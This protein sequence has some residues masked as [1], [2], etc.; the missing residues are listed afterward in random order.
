MVNGLSHLR[1]FWQDFYPFLIAYFLFLIATFYSFRLLRKMTA[2]TLKNLLFNFFIFLFLLVNLFYALEIYYRYIFDATDNIFQIKTTQRW[3]DRHVVI[4]AFGF[5]NDHFF[6]DKAANEIRIMVLGDSYTWGYGIKNQADR[7]SDLLGQQLNQDCRNFG[8]TVKIYN[9]ALPGMSS[10]DE[11]KLI[12][13]YLLKYKI[14]AVVIAYYL[15]DGGSELTARHIQPCYNR[16]F[17]YRY[18]PVLREALNAS[19]ALEYLYV[20][21]YHRFVF[22]TF[23]EVCWTLNYEQ[24]YYD[25]EL[26]VRHLLRLQEIIN[27]TRENQVTLA[28]FLLPYLKFIGPAYPA[29]SIHQRLVNFFEANKVAVLDL[30]PIFSNYKPKELMV[31]Q[32]DYHANELAHRLAFKSLYLKIKDIK[33]FSCHEK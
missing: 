28:V 31:S 7:W 11:A 10:R 26:W 30:L 25:P 8:K 15:D 9:L 19:Y 24:Q 1:Y 3:K 29:T 5:R 32:F 22:P 6:E 16:I 17:A 33:P 2:S 20:R 4:N 27:Y 12:K 21:F 14:D 23:G 13:D 18:V